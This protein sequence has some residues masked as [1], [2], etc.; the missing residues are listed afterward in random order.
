MNKIMPRKDFDLKM[1]PMWIQYIIAL[2]VVAVVV[3]AA[4]IVGHNQP[5]PSWITTNLISALGWLYIIL[6]V[7]VVVN[8]LF[9]KK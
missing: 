3:T 6:F 5:V 4:W 8:R 9:Q 2:S 1:L 7:Y